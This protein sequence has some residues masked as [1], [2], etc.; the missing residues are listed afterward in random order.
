MNKIL[1]LIFIGLF[2]NGCSIKD[3]TA[4]IVKYD[5][6]S[7]SNLNKEKQNDKILKISQFKTPDTLLG[8]EIWYKRKSSQTGAYLY[9]SWNQNFSSMVEQSVANTLYKSELFKSVFI[10]YSK[11]KYDLV[12]EGDIIKAIQNV[13]KNYASVAFEMRL[14]LIDAKNSKLLG[15]KDF[16][17]TKRC[18]SVDALGAVKAY[19]DIFKIFNKEVILWLKKSIK[20]N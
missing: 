12:L 4:P 9:S 15:T 3:V 10:G 6:Q 20:E 17:Y 7:M 19:N 5:I 13:N 14:Y 18:K 1:A 8:D 2:I 16:A 11:V